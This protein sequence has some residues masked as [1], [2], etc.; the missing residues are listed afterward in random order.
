LFVVYDR[1]NSAHAVHDLR[2]NY[3]ID[4]VR[5]TLKWKDFNLFREHLYGSKIWF[6]KPETKVEEVLR[7]ANIGMRARWPRTHLQAQIVTVN[8]F[9][10]QIFKPDQGNDDL[11]RGA[12][13][14]HRTIQANIKEYR[15][16]T[17]LV[18][19]SAH[20]DSIGFF[21]SR[22]GTR[23]TA[24]SGQRRRGGSTR[25]RSFYA[26]SGGASLGGNPRGPGGFSGM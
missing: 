13:L 15:S 1:W 8:Q 21:S 24:G 18:N 2:T 17:R 7:T 22:N 6:S 5:Y 3:S 20:P 19:Y 26:G 4:A 12:A 25:R 11:F 23:S 9:G 10:K 14:C 16:K